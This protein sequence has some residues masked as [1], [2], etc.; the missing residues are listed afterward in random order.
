MRHLGNGFDGES[1]PNC[2]SISLLLGRFPVKE[3]S[4]SS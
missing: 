3:I 1:K 4:I 2:L